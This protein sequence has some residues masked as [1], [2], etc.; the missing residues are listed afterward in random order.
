[1]FDYTGTYTDLYQLRMAQVYFLKNNNTPAV[2]DYFF[3]KLPFEGGY[4]LFSG[5]EDLLELL[6][7]FYFDEKDLRFLHAQGF[8]PDFL[9]YL[10]EFRFEGQVYASNEGDLVFPARPVLS[11]EAPIIQAQLVETILLNILNFQTLIAT[12]ASRIRQASGERTLIDFG[13]RRAQ[14]PGGYYASRA[15]IVGGFN[16]TSNVRVGRDYNIPIAGTMAHSFIQSYDDE[17]S[18]FRDFASIHPDNCVL[19]VDTYNT[20]QSGL[21]NAIKIGKEMEACGQ[22]LQGIRLDS[23]NLESLA[24]KARKMLDEAGL[25]HVKIAASNQLDEWVIKDLLEK[26]APIDIFGVGT[27]LAIGAADAVLDGVFKLAFS[28]NKA[29]IKLSDDKTKI[30]IPCKKQVY[31]VMNSDGRFWGADLIAFEDEGNLDTLYPIFDDLAPQSLEPYRFEPLLFKVME[32]G[33]RLFLPKTLKEIAEYAQARLKL[34]PDEYKELDKPKPYKVG[35][36]QSLKK[37]RNR[38]IDKWKSS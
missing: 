37:E 30:T 20:L 7:S 26:K 19:L 16:A 14:G 11:I 29:R 27:N 24:K 36:S 28:D 31:R 25:N 38:L 32:S 5:L 13:L 2:F 1:M 17:L 34:L 6:E 22:A 8:H 18:A 33:K 15:A 21:V 12:K 9:N 35:L 23:G 10:K 4:A 3:R